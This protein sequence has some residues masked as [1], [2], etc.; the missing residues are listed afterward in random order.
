MEGAL[1]SAIGLA[2]AESVRKSLSTAIR[3]RARVLSG[4]E[5]EDEL[6]S[7]RVFGDEYC[8]PA[9]TICVTPGNGPGRRS[10]SACV[11]GDLPVFE[12]PAEEAVAEV[13]AAR[14]DLDVED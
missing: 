1:G 11:G 5:D 13:G 9:S 14:R 3:R 6:A 10:V 12:D 2:A 8:V 4:T 7:E